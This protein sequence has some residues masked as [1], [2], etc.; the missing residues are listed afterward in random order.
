MARQD[1]QELNIDELQRLEHMLDRGLSRVLQTK[2]HVIK[3]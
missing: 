2:V 3:F 1:L